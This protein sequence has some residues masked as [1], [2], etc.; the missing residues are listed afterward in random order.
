MEELLVDPQVI[1]NGYIGEVPADGDM[2]GYRLPAVPVQFDE[3]PPTLRRAPELGEHTET[4]LLELGY[5]WDS[6][7]QLQDGGI[8]P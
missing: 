8:I 5:E 2:P 1:A 3:A 7:A 6:I 4:L